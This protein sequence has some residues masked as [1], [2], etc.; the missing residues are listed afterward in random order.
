MK[1]VFF[2]LLIAN[3]SFAGNDVSSEEG[4]GWRDSDTITTIEKSYLGKEAWFTQQNQYNLNKV[5]PP[6]RVN[7]S[8]E[9]DN[10]TKRLERWNNP[11]KISYIYLL[12]DM[13]SVIGYFPIKGK[14]SS[15]N[16]KLTTTSQL[17]YADASVGDSAS[18]VVESADIDGSYGSNGDAVFWFLVDGTYMEWNGKY[19]LSDRPVKLSIRPVM[20]Y[21]VNAAQEA[22][23]VETTKKVEVKKS[24][25]KKGKW[26]N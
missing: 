11:N 15:V 8:L 4:M 20:T 24:E 21:S 2:L 14:V 3:V 6:P 22:K 7:W 18:G 12:S 9:R 10:L 5:Q 25:S 19:F 26:R 23:K 13:G 1:L 17:L 16:S